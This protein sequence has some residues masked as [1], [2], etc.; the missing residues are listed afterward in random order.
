FAPPPPHSFPTRRS[1]DLA[2][3]LGVVIG[4]VLG[5]FAARAG[6]AAPG[7]VAAALCLCN[8]GFAWKWLPESRVL[9][10]HTTTG[11]G[12]HVPPPEPRSEEH[13]YELQSRFDLV[14]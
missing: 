4:P 8:V 12:R 3:S 11:S 9:P 13:T 14:C 6:Q 10:S 7:L 5:S 2:T 1:S